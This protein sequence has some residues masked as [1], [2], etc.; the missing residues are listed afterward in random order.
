MKHKVQFIGLEEDEKDLIVSFAVDDGKMSVKSLILHR[1]PVFEAILDEDQRGVNVS[2]EGEYLEE[3]EYNMLNN[4]R[5][6]NDEIVVQST[7]RKY[8]L[9]IT[10]VPKSEITDM[11]KLLKKQNYDN[12]FTID[13]A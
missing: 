7:F 12:R 2:M 3:E 5:I 13:I 11:V 1:T 6:T 8:K 10:R 4:I 9:D